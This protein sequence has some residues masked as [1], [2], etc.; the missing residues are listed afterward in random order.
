MLSQGVPRP[1]LNARAEELKA[2]LIKKKEQRATS[3]TPPIITKPTA[4]RPGAQSDGTNS[5]RQS[6]KTPSVPSQVVT[7]T[8]AAQSITADDLEDLLSEAK[9]AVD[10]KQEQTNNAVNGIAAQKPK[11]VE[12]AKPHAKIQAQPA[13]AIKSESN[14]Q[15]K[16]ANGTKV[17]QE[18]LQRLE[19]SAKKH[20]GI[21]DRPVQPNSSVSKFSEPKANPTRLNEQVLSNS[22]RE[23]AHKTSVNPDG[24]AVSNESIS[25]SLS[26]SLQRDDHRCE[27][28]ERRPEQQT[29]AATATGE[30]RKHYES[31]QVEE[32]ARISQRR[33]QSDILEAARKPEFIPVPKKDAPPTQSENSTLEQL[34]LVDEDLKEWLDITGW[35]NAEYR[36]K[37]LNRR[38]AIAALDAQKAKLLE[39]ME[40]EERGALLPAATGGSQL[41]VKAMPPPP[42]VLST[43]IAIPISPIVKSP[44]PIVEKVS[45]SSTSAIHTKKESISKRTYNDY[46]DESPEQNIDKDRGDDR[47]RLVR[48]RSDIEDENRHPRPR[49][50]PRS[51]DYPQYSPRYDD[52][53]MDYTYNR[54]RGRGVGDSYG[55]ELSPGTKALLSRQPAGSARSMSYDAPNDQFGR[56]EHNEPPRTGKSRPLVVRGNYRGRAFDPNYN[57]GGGGIGRGRG[58]GSSF[59]ERE[60]KIEKR[61]SSPERR[62]SALDYARRIDDIP[63][64]SNMIKWERGGRGG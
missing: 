15:S 41:T 37:T 46:R 38:R 21:K 48:M 19:S 32:S 54:G 11:I 56:V 20:E 33:I 3:G 12:A 60:D 59:F 35:N 49:S 6:P 13:N 27:E 47:S 50:R 14:T 30:E 25:N 36:K 9:A 2:Q 51:R 31:R 53:A 8:S 22:Q 44:E 7:P 39:E 34:L 62:P 28:V 40:R 16:T 55:R 58:P 63:P 18:T 43:P 1:A 52:R 57:R 5:T 4:M 10:V 61:A 26:L 29:R 23:T 64:T 45:V 42:L 17:R 24:H